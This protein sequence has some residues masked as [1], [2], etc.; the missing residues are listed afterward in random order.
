M[1]SSQGGS[2]S[3]PTPPTH[4]GSVS[5]T[6]SGASTAALNGAHR[7]TS[8]GHY[9]ASSPSSLDPMVLSTASWVTLTQVVFRISSG[10]S[11]REVARELG[12]TRRE[13][14]ASLALLREELLDQ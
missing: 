8:N 10:Y 4:S 3:P 14:E 12:Q 7:T 13:V 1:T 11:E 6:G 2:G 5:S 9:Q